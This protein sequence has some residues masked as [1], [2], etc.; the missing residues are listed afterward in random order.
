MLVTGTSLDIVSGRFVNMYVYNYSYK[1][2]VNPACH[3]SYTEQKVR[4][5]PS[6]FRDLQRRCLHLFSQVQAFSAK[7]EKPFRMRLI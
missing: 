1:S 4:I 5:S 7:I 6:V 2:I 3:G